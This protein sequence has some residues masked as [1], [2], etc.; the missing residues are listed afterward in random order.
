MDLDY[1]GMANCGT[2]VV[3]RL[4]T[5]NDRK[6]LVE[7]VCNSVPGLQKNVLTEKIGGLNPRHFLL[8]RGGRLVP[9]LSRDVT[10]DLRGPMDMRDIA[11]LGIKPVPMT[12][13]GKMKRSMGKV[14]NLFGK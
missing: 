4:Q 5:T 3:G 12:R 9:F 11:A 7:G 13:G 2:W 10:C 6:R 8:A 14:L 1:K